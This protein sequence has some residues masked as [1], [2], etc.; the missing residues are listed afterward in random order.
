MGNKYFN[1][2]ITNSNEI[3][4]MDTDFINKINNLYNDVTLKMDELQISDAISVIFDLLRAS[5]KYIDETTPWVLAKDEKRLKRLQTVIYNL[6]ES[7]R[8]SA[9]FLNP[10]LPDTS[11]S[12]LNQLNINDKSFAFNKNNIYNLNK[13]EPLFMRIDLNKKKD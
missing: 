12:I 6:V 13:P 5:N 8:V 2:V 9:V 7:I 11:D 4:D 3:E 10:F 1:G